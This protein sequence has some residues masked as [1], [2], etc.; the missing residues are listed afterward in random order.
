MDGMATEQGFYAMVSYYRMLEEKTS[1]YDMTDVM[2]LGG[3]P[4]VQPA[5]ETEAAAEEETE[6]EAEE[7]EKKSMIPGWVR[8]VAIALLAATIVAAGL[9][10]FLMR[11]NIFGP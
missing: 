10:V 2:D 7:P 8:P 5:V 6:P 9:A 1:L 3:V 11:K 4:K